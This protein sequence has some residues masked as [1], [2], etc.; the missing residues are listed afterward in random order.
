MIFTMHGTFLDIDESQLVATNTDF[1]FYSGMDRM[2]MKLN[3]RGA[4]FEVLYT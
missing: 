3:L 2:L 1:R 4:N